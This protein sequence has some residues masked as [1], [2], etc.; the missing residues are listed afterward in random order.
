MRGA[1]LNTQEMYFD[2]TNINEGITAKIRDLHDAGGSREWNDIAEAG[3]LFDMET[4]VAVRKTLVESSF[5]HL[6]ELQDLGEL[7]NKLVTHTHWG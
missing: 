2:F 6:S 5:P 4:L 3:I 1:L 7:I